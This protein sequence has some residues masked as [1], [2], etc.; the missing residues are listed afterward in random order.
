M[1][2]SF[3]VAEWIPAFAGMTQRLSAA[4]MTPWLSTAGMT[5]RLSAV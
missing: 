4:G 5:P 1:P 2:E 3:F